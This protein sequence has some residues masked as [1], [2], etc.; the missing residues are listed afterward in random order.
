M[1]GWRTVA[2][3]LLTMVVPIME[4]TEWQTLLPEDW[5]PYWLLFVG[6]ANVWLRAITTTPMGRRE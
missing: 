5:L 1:K 6:V 3:N 4:L 2:F